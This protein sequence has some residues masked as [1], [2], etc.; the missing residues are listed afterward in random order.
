M[1]PSGEKAYILVIDDDQLLTATIKKILKKDGYFV[2][3]AK[4]GEEGIAKA[5][6]GFFHLV[7]CDLR[8]PGLD[9]L[10]TIRHIQNFQ[11]K[12]GVDKT[13]F[14]LITA[15][16]APETRQE[17]F[18]LGVSDF[19]LKPFDVDKF[20]EVIHHHTRQLTAKTPEED[21]RLYNERLSRLLAAM[22]EEHPK[23]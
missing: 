17:A 2:D 18:Q 22:E 7:L 3:V 13:G 1:N 9:G 19:I 20:L 4:R 11:K 23:K 5:K 16:D 8:M 6:S 21:V 14:I 15:Y 12:A 10:M